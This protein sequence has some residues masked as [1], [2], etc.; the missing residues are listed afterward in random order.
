MEKWKFN[1]GLINFAL[2]A[3]LK[4]SDTKKRYDAMTLKILSH[5]KTISILHSLS[6]FY[7]V[8]YDSDIDL[9]FTCMIVNSTDAQFKS[10]ERVGH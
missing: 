7:I 6:L 10:D 1:V 8:V 2:S 3:Q 5:Y 4:Y 9:H